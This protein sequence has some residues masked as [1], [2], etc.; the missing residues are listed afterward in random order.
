MDNGHFLYSVFNLS[1]CL[2]IFCFLTWEAWAPIQELNESS[3]TLG[4]ASVEVNPGCVNIWRPGS[5]YVSLV[6]SYLPAYIG[7]SLRPFCS[8]V[9]FL[10]PKVFSQ[11]GSC[12]TDI[13]VPHHDWQSDQHVYSTADI[14]VHMLSGC[15]IN[16]SS[17]L[18]SWLF[19]RPSRFAALTLSLYPEF[20]CSAFP[21]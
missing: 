17:L 20:I 6:M 12:L 16:D 15:P 18:V 11:P 1:F 4:F 13:Y 7:K 14:S 10:F 9:L 21:L 19:L 3:Q 8:F 2:N 5:L